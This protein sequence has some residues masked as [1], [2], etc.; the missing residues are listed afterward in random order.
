M[1]EGLLM[2]QEK[3]VNNRNLELCKW[4]QMIAVIRAALEY[5]HSTS[6]RNDFLKA[7][8]NLNWDEYQRHKKVQLQAMNELGKRFTV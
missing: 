4:T 3:Q 2:H 6:G 5:Q 1:I 7:L 8:T